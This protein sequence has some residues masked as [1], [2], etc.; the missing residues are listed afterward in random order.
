[1]ENVRFSLRG[2]MSTPEEEDVPEVNDDVPEEK[3]D[4]PEEKKDAP[5]EKNY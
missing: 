3:K 5:E 1:M 4:A 2:K